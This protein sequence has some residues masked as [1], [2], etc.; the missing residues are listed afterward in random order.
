MLHQLAEQL[1][2][3]CHADDSK[4]R[5]G[6]KLKT[7]WM[8]GRMSNG[9]LSTHDASRVQHPFQQESEVRLVGEFSLLQV[10]S[11]ARENACKRE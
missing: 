9:M 2:D 11:K 4:A 10:R 6:A 8:N 7:S 1:H 3:A 5:Y